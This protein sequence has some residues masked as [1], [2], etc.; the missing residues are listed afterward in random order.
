MLRF[1]NGVNTLIDE[2]WILAHG[3]T[4]YLDESMNLFGVLDDDK[5]PLLPY[6]V[7]WLKTESIPDNWIKTLGS[8]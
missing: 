8:I 6:P 7:M 1:D 3:G 5:A 4:L 2:D